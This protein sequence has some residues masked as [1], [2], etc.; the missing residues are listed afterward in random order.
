MAEGR[1]RR[2]VSEMCSRGGE[3]STLRVLAAEPVVDAQGDGVSVASVV[4]ADTVGASRPDTTGDD[5]P[6][7]MR[8]L[9]VRCPKTSGAV[10]LYIPTVLP[11]QVV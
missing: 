5:T 8:N 6:I 1:G 7:D 11:S 4:L 3:K 10:P 2:R 9:A